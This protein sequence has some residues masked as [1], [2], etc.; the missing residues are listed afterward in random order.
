MVLVFHLTILPLPILPKGD[1]LAAALDSAETICPALN[2]ARQLLLAP[3]GGCLYRRSPAK[4]AIQA[5]VIVVLFFAN[6][7]SVQR[8]A[9]HTVH[10][11]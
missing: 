1:G 4:V 10:D 11:L 6:L 2:F 8:G 3:G 9:R 5:S 7:G